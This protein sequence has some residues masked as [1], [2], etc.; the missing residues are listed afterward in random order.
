MADIRCVVGVGDAGG[1]V[2][3]HIRVTGING[4]TL[5][6]AN[7]YG[8]TLSQCKAHVK[9]QLGSSLMGAGGNPDTGKK[10][11]EESRDTLLE[12]LASADEVIIV[13]GMGG[14]TGTGASPVI[15]ELTT[16]AG[17]RTRAVV[18]QPSTFEGIHRK[19]IAE[20]GIRALRHSV[21]DMSVVET[22]Q[23]IKLL[24]G[25]DYDQRML[26]DLIC[27]ALAWKTIF[28]LAGK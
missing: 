24:A 20:S 25:A 26:S 16:T 22:D 14:G 5:I 4:V 17:I 19:Q 13:A 6:A 3:N 7:T 11:A 23:L 9:I 21:E 15:A 8:Y 27:A 2:L 1:L 18:S 28:T 12:H 10:A